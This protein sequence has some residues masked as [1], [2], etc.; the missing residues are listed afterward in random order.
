MRLPN[1][2]WCENS[3]IKTINSKGSGQVSADPHKARTTCVFFDLI[4]VAVVNSLKRAVF[5]VE[6][7]GLGTMLVAESAHKQSF[8][9]NHKLHIPFFVSIVVVRTHATVIHDV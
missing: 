1:W 2:A 9:L 4:Y 6:C 8:A 5:K 7:Y 3:I